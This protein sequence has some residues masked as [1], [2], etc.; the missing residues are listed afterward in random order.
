MVSTPFMDLTPMKEQQLNAITTKHTLNNKMVNVMD[1]NEQQGAFPLKG[2]SFGLT[3]LEYASLLIAQG[4]I[5]N[6][7]YK[8]DEGYE[9]AR[10]SVNVAK[11][12]LEESNK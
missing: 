9:I 6:G 11:L 10:C 5:A 4:Y 3:K 12:V 8:N 7:A 1:N 2:E